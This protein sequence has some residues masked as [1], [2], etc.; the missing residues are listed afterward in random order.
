MDSKEPNPIESKLESAVTKTDITQ[1][2]DLKLYTEEILE[3]L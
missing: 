2:S 1:N 3:F